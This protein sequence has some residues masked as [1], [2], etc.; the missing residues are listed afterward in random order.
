[1]DCLYVDLDA[2]L[3]GPGG[4]LFLDAEK[5]FTL[6]GARALEACARAGCE[7]VLMT[8]RREDTVRENARLFSQTSYIFEAGSCVVIEGEEHWLTAPLLP[9]ETTVHDQITAVGAPALLLE[10]YAGRLEYHDPWHADREVSHLFRGLLDTDEADALLAANGH[11]NLRLLDNG[12]AHR[13]S[14]AL[15]ALRDLRVYHLLW[16]N[17]VVQAVRASQPQVKRS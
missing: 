16:P 8:G 7:V 13:R 5:R 11:E 3:L 4:S 14:P 9:G 6:L 10:T 12:A 17:P 15:A 1:M 2:T